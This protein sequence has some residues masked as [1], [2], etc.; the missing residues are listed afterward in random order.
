MFETFLL[1]K[2]K[3]NHEERLM[4]L[5]GLLTFE[6]VPVVERTSGGGEVFEKHF[7]HIILLQ[8]ADRTF[9]PVGVFK[10]LLYL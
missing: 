9:R 1:L 6:A 5:N 10:N 3:N 8:R 4:F 7:K 2:H